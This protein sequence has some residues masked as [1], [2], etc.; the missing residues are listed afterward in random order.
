MENYI[1]KLNRILAASGW[2]QEDLSDQLDVSFVTLNKW[3]NG[4][5]EPRDSAKERID[6]VAA[7]IL[8]SDDVDLAELARVKKHAMA[9]KFSVRRLVMD[10]EMLNRIT[11]NLT[12]HSNATE[13]ST[14]TE[15]DVEA[16]IFDNKVLKNRT[17]VEQREA[18]NHQTALNFLIDELQSQ[19]KEFVFTSDLIRAT[20]L[21]L[22]NGIIS[23]AGE[24]RNHGARIRGAHVPLANFIKISELIKLWCGEVNEE[25]ADPIALLAKSHAEFERVHPFSDGNGRTGRLL[26]FIKA[27]HLGLV[28]PVI[29][30]QRR[31][32]YYKYLEICQVRE[33]SDPLEMFVAEAIIE[34]ADELDDME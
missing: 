3:I 14:M 22:M 33:L 9:Q 12:Y 26:L 4:K 32:A 34:T 17:A 31:A 11:V 15:S 24:Y 23:D 10:R 5:A 25:T 2:S 30:K 28:P 29:K 1:E 16:V 18:I 8:G 27:L 21:R 13:G 19:G 7:E 6:Q 20:H